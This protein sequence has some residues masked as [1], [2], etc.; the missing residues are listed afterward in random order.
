[1][2][3]I[4]LRESTDFD[5][6]SSDEELKDAKYFNSFDKLVK[7]MLRSGSPVDN[8]FINFYQTRNGSLINEINAILPS[9]S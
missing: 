5:Q 3:Q 9:E 6:T 8:R 7:S 1:M 4:V 2:S